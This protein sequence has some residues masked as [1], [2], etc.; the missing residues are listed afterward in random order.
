MRPYLV[1][2]SALACLTLAGLFAANNQ[3][4]LT[5]LGYLKFPENST[6]AY[7][8]A[9][10]GGLTVA[11]GGSNQ[12]LVLAPSGTGYVAAGST[13]F[14]SWPALTSNLFVQNC[15]LAASTPGN[16]A[17]S[18]NNA[19]QTYLNA[20]SGQTIHFHLANVIQGIW[21]TIGLSI[22]TGVNANY[23]LDVAGDVNTSTGYRVSGTAG[24]S[25]T[26]TIPGGGS[27]T[28]AGG[29]VTAYTNPASGAT[30]T[31]TIPGGGSATLNAGIATGFTN[32]TA[33]VSGTFT[34]LNGGSITIVSGVVTAFTSSG[35]GSTPSTSSGTISGTNNSWHVA[36][37]AGTVTSVTVTWA[38]TFNP[39]ACTVSTSGVTGGGSLTVTTLSSTSVVVGAAANMASS[40]IY[41]ICY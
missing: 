20:A 31:L 30:G 7:L 40:Q 11:S 35:G 13:C 12:N 32:P 15:A 4:L 34:T 25:A 2:L 27:F 38:G 8:Y 36:V 37:A 16:Y 17:L 23:P 9:T 6:P 26:V 10:G 33:T 3:P 19:G 41:G 14:G 1:A 18:Q 39:T 21:S 29:I 28:A 22:L 5:G 24:Q